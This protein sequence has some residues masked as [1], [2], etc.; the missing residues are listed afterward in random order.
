MAE[1][2]R[3]L[4]F[5]DRVQVYIPQGFLWQEMF[6]GTSHSCGIINTGA[7]VAVTTDVS[8]AFDKI[9]CSRVQVSFRL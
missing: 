5:E 4:E 8:S 3:L 9:H 1:L 2:E 6:A 7:L